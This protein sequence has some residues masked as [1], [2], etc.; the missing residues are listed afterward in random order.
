MLL[1]KRFFWR[2]GIRKAQQI[3]VPVINDISNLQLPRNAVFHYLAEDDINYGTPGDHWS[4]KNAER[5][6]MMEHVEEL[7]PNAMEGPPKKLAVIPSTLA[8]TYHRKNRKIKMVRNLE[9]NTKEPRTILVVNYAILP[10]V[11]RYVKNFFIDLYRWKNITITLIEKI[12]SLNKQIDRQHFIFHE[13]PTPLPSLALIKRAEANLSRSVLEEFKTPEHLF[14]L[15]VWKWLGP[16]RSASLLSKLSEEDV[17]KVNLIWK[18]DNFWLLINLGVL[19]DLRKVAEKEEGDFSP[20]ILQ[21]RFLRM[22]MSLFEATTPTTVMDDEDIID[23]LEDEE[24]NI[25]IDDINLD[26]DTPEIPKTT[27]DKTVKKN[28]ETTIIKSVSTSLKSDD[29][30]DEELEKELDAVNTIALKKKAEKE[31]N[32]KEESAFD[33]EVPTLDYAILDKAEK[34]AEDGIISAAEFRRFEKLAVNYKE[35]PDPYTGKGKAVETL[36]VTADDIALPEPVH[37]PDSQ[38]ILDKSMNESTLE[39]FDKK[40]IKEVLRKDIVN[41][42]INVHKAGVAIN[43]YDVEAKHDIAN[44]YEHHIIRFT[45]VTGKPSTVHFKVPIIREDGTFLANNTKYSFRKQRSD[46]PIRKVK[47]NKVALT[48]YYGKVFVER[49]SKVVHDYA[50]WLT[51]QIR[52]KGLDT[53]D[54]SV[55][56]IKI[57]KTN[58]NALTLPRLYSILGSSF[59]SF[60]AANYHFDFG[61]SKRKEVYGEELVNKLES[62]GLIIIGHVL[63]SSDELLLVDKNDTLYIGY[64]NNEDLKVVGK[65]ED[66]VGLDIEKAPMD[67]VEVGVFGKAIPIGFVLAYYVGLDNLINSLPGKVRRVPDGERLH[68][69][70]DEHAIRFGDDTLVINRDD[71]LTSMILGSLNGFKKSL[72]LYSINDFNEKDVYFN[73]LDENGLGVRYL[74][75]MDLLNSMFIDPITLEILQEMKEPVTWLGLLKR[76]VE[77]LTTDYSPSEVDMSSM[78]IKGYER[79]A[80]A[81][82]SELVNSLRAYSLMEGSPNNTVE[83][84]PFAV[85]QAIMDDQSK[86]LVEESNP[87]RNLKEK[88]SVTFTGAGGRSKESMVGRTRIFDKNDMGIISEATVDSG[89]VAIN[90][91]LSPNPKFKNL[92]GLTEPLKEG[93]IVNS[94]VLSTS[95]LISPASTF[96]DAKRTNFVSIQH[97][98]GISANGYQVTPLRT[99]YERVIAHRT[100]DLYATTAKQ[101]G[102]VKKLGKDFI[103]V[104]YKDGSIQTIELGRRFGRAVDTHY[105]YDLVSD[106]KEGDKVK[107]G[108]AIAYNKNFFTP[109]PLNPKQVLWKA[110]VMCKVAILESTDTFE[111][112]SAISERAAQL[113]GTHTTKVRHLFF[114]FDQSISNLI[115]VGS[116]VEPDTVLCTIEDPLTANNQ[117]FDDETLDTLRLLSGNTPRAKYAGVVEKIE[118]LYYGD[119]DDMTDSLRRVADNFDKDLAKKRKALGLPIVSGSVD[120]GIRIDK[121]V[122][123]MDTLVIKVYITNNIPAAQGDKG[124]FGNQMKT[125][126]TRVMGGVNETE[127][128]EPID[129]IFGYQ[130][131]IARIVTSPEVMGTT[132]TLLRVLSKHVAKVYNEN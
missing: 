51:T 14:M 61:Y 120:D 21:K 64:R 77:L 116:K 6:V 35:L 7:S 125:I 131:I 10:H 132:N 47:P 101:P 59:D 107:E 83:M 121:K 44:E 58:L 102:V 25:D 98:Q 30:T 112:S 94:S 63:E 46:L 128:G 84:K 13:I 72:R 50:Q 16:N 111:D 17:K 106:L 33:I 41:A 82:Y 105:P 49:S 68:L 32:K 27:I 119:K 55:S 96:D 5:L 85:W 76:S 19:E 53:T 123:D 129:A 34:L 87:I 45:P 57:S 122:I 103:T 42:V 71:A 43:N 113:L 86:I 74:K 117:L 91:A 100:D 65:I 127:S 78:R 75:E 90:T 126:F 130:S 97:D 24:D 114:N 115:E 109:D 23:E 18:W 12:I 52:N 36:K 92:R 31:K 110:G 70:N 95:A 93:E 11:Y 26:I 2:F 4:V 9:A 37:Y 69:S 108:D 124:V 73:V 60:N 67:I 39:T 80:G 89:D 3:T 56:D 99:G 62:E 48:S 28:K 1:F 29:K 104:E 66:V 8:R 38:F 81:V 15:E 22:L 20:E 118:V 54:N 40:Y 88:E 79:I